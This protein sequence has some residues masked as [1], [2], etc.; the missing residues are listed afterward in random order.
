MTT[1][2][3]RTLAKIDWPRVAADMHAQGYAHV[4]GL[5]TADACQ[6]LISAYD[7]SELY[8]KTITMER[9][10]FGLGEYKYFTYPL[11]EILQAIRETVYPQL[12]PIA[13]QWMEWLGLEQ[14]FPAAFA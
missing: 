6:K 12:A 4:P 9:Y 10:R 14:R 2:I 11:P 5:L 3:L 13:N 8:R 7:E 1:S